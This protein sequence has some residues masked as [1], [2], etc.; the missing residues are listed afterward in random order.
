M[1]F[2][3]LFTFIGIDNNLISTRMSNL[4]PKLALILISVV[5]TFLM[6]KNLTENIVPLFKFDEISKVDIINH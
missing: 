1:V 3:K 2:S 4:I 5:E 6:L